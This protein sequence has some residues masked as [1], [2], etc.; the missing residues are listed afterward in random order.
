MDN[1]RELA[2]K[3]E[4]E[5]ERERQRQALDEAQNKTMMAMRERQEAVA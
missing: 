3:Q 5:R 4:R 2:Q 1:V